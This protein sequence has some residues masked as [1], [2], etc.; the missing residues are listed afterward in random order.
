M[1][2]WEGFDK[3]LLPNKE[4][5]YSSLN[6]ED[7]ANVDYTH[8]KKVYKK[9]NNKNLVIFMICMFKVIHYYL[10]MCLKILEINVL[11]Y[12]YLILLIFYQHPD[13]HGKLI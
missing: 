11:K 7:I 12:I 13:Y 5:F 8:A 1:D 3:D 4:A 10:L 6:I 9:F 2:S